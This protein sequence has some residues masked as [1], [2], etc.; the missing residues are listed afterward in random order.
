MLVE[1]SGWTKDN[2]NFFCE[3]ELDETK[4]DYEI[5]Y[6]NGEIARQTSPF[7]LVTRD[8]N[9]DG[10]VYSKLG[11]WFEHLNS[12]GSFKHGF[13]WGPEDMVRGLIDSKDPSSTYYGDRIK[14]IPGIEIPP[15]ARRPSLE[16]HLQSSERRRMMQDA[17]RT[18]KMNALG[19]RHPG[20]P[21]AK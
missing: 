12:D 18:R 13:F 11:A 4:L 20:D 10:D 15:P 19:I 16:D 7:Q 8:W 9:H 6:E 14:A 3:I 5:H 21:W 2:G 17:E 1:Y